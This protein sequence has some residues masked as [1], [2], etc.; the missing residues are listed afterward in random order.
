MWNSSAEPMP[1]RISTSNSCFQR[2]YS[3]SGSASPAE[4]QTRSGA[5]DFDAPTC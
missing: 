4:M 2:W 3:Y 1:S 5:S